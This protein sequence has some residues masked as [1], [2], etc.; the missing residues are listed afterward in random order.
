[1]PETFKVPETGHGEHSAN[2]TLKGKCAF[3][4]GSSAGLGEATAKRLARDGARVIV[5][6][7]N[8]ERAERVASEIRAAGGEAFV[9]FGDLASNDTAQQV[10][11]AVRAK[12][13]NVDI[14]VNNAGGD[15]GGSGLA[16]WL[17]VTPDAWVSTYQANTVSVVRMIHAFV[18]EMRQRGW[19][20]VI[21]ICS[22]VGH[23]PQVTSPDYAG[24]KASLLNMTV[25]LSRELAQTGITSNS[26]SPG[27]IL[28]K[29][30][31]SW[32]QGI[33]QKLGWGSSWQ[34]IEKKVLE[35]F[36]P[37]R[38][39]RMGLPEDVAHAVAYLASN[40]A[41]YITGIDIL[42]SGGQAADGKRMGS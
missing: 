32:L 28:T 35:E 41:G 33:A 21:Q 12:K 29:H 30:C 9:V 31:E 17:D 25:S 3:V 27:L 2:T 26:V 18:P 23:D 19:G 39:G 15:S 8:K 40:G 24:A 5:H 4:T 37:N 22:V 1:V 11:D 13:W 42:V 7:R 16:G 6:G 14:L 10:V 20:R 36:E 38:I 34:A